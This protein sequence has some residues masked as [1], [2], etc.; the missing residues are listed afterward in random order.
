[1]VLAEDLAGSLLSDDSDCIFHIYA[2]TAL[3]SVATGCLSPASPSSSS[4]YPPMPPHYDR[5]PKACQRFN[6]PNTS[7]YWH[8]N[9]LVKEQIIV[10]LLSSEFL[11]W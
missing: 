6:A 7:K 2:T 8:I 4:L 9:F 10:S 11:A 1:M 5:G 3:S